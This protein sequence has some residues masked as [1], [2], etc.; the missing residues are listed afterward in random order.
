MGVPQLH[1]YI[2]ARTHAVK[3]GL[4]G[5]IASGLCMDIVGSVHVAAAKYNG[6]ISLIA[7][8]VTED[9]KDI[10]HA[11]SPKS[12][13]LIAFDG[14]SPLAKVMHRK[15]RRWNSALTG[16]TDRFTRHITTEES[17]VS[18][19]GT[20][21]DPNSIS[22]GTEFMD[23]V[24]KGIRSRLKT[25]AS[26]NKQLKFWFTSHRFPGEGEHKIFDYLRDH[27]KSH[28]RTRGKADDTVVIY[29]NDADLMLL[30][31]IFDKC[32]VVVMRMIETSQDVAKGESTVETAELSQ[33]IS[34][35]FSYVH[36]DDIREWLKIKLWPE[37]SEPTYEDFVLMTYMLGNDFL[38]P[39]MECE[40]LLFP[41]LDE[42]IR[43][44]S[45]M[46]R[47]SR[48]TLVN[49]NFSVNWVNFLRFIKRLNISDF[50]VQMS[51]LKY[52]DGHCSLDF[53][54]IS[55][56]DDKGIYKGVSNV[57]FKEKYYS[58]KLGL[59]GQKFTQCNSGYDMLNINELVVRWM[60]TILW[61][62]LYYKKGTDDTGCSV[63]FYY[64]FH[65]APSITD[66]MEF[67]ATHE[68]IGDTVDSLCKLLGEPPISHGQFLTASQELIAILPLQSLN[69]LPPSVS[70]L[71]LREA[72]E[73]YPESVHIDKTCKTKEYK[74][75]VMV[76]P[77]DIDKIRRFHSRIKM[78]SDIQ[79]IDELD[80]RKFMP[81][82]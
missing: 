15:R 10:I 50:I 74:H 3:K 75:I 46:N 77:I 16:D 24:V 43:V 12:Y 71:L 35:E 4:D 65:I 60:Q 78:L 27:Y 30:G 52:I 21:F 11:V 59:W 38:P 9:I 64:P 25:Y 44:Y 28:K 80:R 49:S 66:I 55:T 37:R 40:E 72:S 23:N 73:D 33:D 51:N 69:I 61:N 29:G 18:P 42:C 63:E 36:C 2:K 62:L 54:E 70:N 47:G 17:I 31:L 19:E 56:E 58:Y 32:N 1:P 82:N 26:D 76:P 41:V 6:D 5:K 79:I 68:G 45:S 53:A 67:L 34:K 22:S 57:A 14:V 13:V 39:L 7:K 8:A 48:L 81:L 20:K